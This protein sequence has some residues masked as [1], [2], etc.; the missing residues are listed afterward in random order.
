ARGSSVLRGDGGA[1]YES[2]GRESRRLAGLANLPWKSLD[3][4][5]LSLEC[6]GGW[7]G[8]DRGRR[9]DAGSRVPAELRVVDNGAGG[10]DAAGDCQDS[11]KLEQDH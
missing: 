7:F 6:I 10:S 9:D 1:P 11:G 2:N 3:T 8:M 5:Y 4:W